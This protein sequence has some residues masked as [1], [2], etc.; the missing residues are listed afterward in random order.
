MAAGRT[1]LLP[2]R[3]RGADGQE[4]QESLH[5]HAWNEPGSGEKDSTKRG[6]VMV[7]RPAAEGNIDQKIELC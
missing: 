3:G 2:L 5:Q 6:S 1:E 7:M 4:A